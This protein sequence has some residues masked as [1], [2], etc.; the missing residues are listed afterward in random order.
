MSGHDYRA[1]D[2]REVY[3]GAI[4]RL[5]VDTVEMP[6]GSTAERDHLNRQAARLNHSSGS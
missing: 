2:S 1:L 3:D 5:R 4:V 6:G